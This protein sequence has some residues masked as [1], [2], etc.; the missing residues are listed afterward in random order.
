MEFSFSST[1]WLTEKEISSKKKIKN[2]S[3]SNKDGSNE[4]TNILNKY[5]K[6]FDRKYVCTPNRKTPTKNLIKPKYFAPLKPKEDLNIT[7]NGKPNFC[8]GFP[9]NVEKK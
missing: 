1:K 7:T 2:N 3:R 5:P 4:N 8:E 9:I 6:T